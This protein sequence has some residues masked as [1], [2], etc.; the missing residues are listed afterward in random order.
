MTVA[1]TAVLAVTVDVPGRIGRALSGTSVE[2]LFSWPRLDAEL[3][4]VRAELGGR[5][6]RRMDITST[7]SP[8]RGEIAYAPIMH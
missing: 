6:I 2:D 7:S 1:I 8:S 3:D 4:V 5:L